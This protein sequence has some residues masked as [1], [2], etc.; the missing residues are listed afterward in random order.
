MDTQTLL[1][2]GI[3]FLLLLVYYYRMFRNGKRQK[4]TREM[5]RK[6]PQIIDV[7]TPAEF[8]QEHYPGAVNF[9]LKNLHKR[10]KK[11]GNANRPIVVYCKSGS[12]AKQAF[13]MF[14][15]A[16]YTNVVNAGSIKNMPSSS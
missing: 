14:R 2:A 12:R 4:K 15:A 16:G 6:N 3:P 5:M 7:R 8:K 1:F 11:P 13:R 9:P 10:L